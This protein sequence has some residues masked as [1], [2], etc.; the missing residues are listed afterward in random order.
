MSDLFAD[1]RLQ[2]YLRNRDDIQTW[3]AIESDVVAATR[4]LLAR[5]QP[6]IEERL[7]A[8]DPAVLVA[9]NDS[10]PWERILARHASWPESVG[11]TLEW[12]RQVDPTGANRPKIGVFWWAD[13][14]SLIEPRARLTEVLAKA[15][16]YA[17][18]FKVPMGG[19]WPV[20]MFAQADQSWWREPDSWI[21]TLVDKVAETWPLVASTIDEVLGARLTTTQSA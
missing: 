19:V 6:Q 8:Q 17:L 10:G 18:G 4:E 15:P 12:H 9:R 3:A 2:F 14:P 13:P 20:G 1:E 21:E 7:L 5:A 11:L 16:L